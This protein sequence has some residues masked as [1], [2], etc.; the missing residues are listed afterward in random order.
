[1]ASIAAAFVDSMAA[2]VATIGVEFVGIVTVPAITV[3][4]S[5]RSSELY[6]CMAAEL[7]LLR[8]GTSP[9]NESSI[10]VVGSQGQ[11]GGRPIECQAWGEPADEAWGETIGRPIVCRPAA[12]AFVTC[13]PI[14]TSDGLTIRIRADTYVRRPDGRDG[15]TA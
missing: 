9:P 10:T 3:A 15:A 5:P 4:T 8:R 1:M 11:A 6:D 7:N 13:L 2:G 14:D 12:P